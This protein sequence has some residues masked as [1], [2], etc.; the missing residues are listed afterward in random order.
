VDQTFVSSRDKLPFVTVPPSGS[1]GV[2][3]FERKGVDGKRYVGTA[4]GSA[5]EV[6]ENYFREQVPNAPK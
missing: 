3:A 4:Q 6:D 2:V 5:Y 1:S